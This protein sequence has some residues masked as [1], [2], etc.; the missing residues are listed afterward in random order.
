MLHE[1][2]E[3]ATAKPS[4]VPL[5]V[6][7]ARHAEALRQRKH[8][9][10]P[11]AML[12]QFARA[13]DART[14]VLESLSMRARNGLR[15]VHLGTDRFGNQYWVGGGQWA[16]LMIHSDAPVWTTPGTGASADRY[17]AEAVRKY[18]ADRGTW[19]TVSNPWALRSLVFGYLSSQGTAEA[20]LTWRLRR[21][22]PL[23][24]R[25]MKKLR[26]CDAMLGTAAPTA[27]VSVSVEHVERAGLL[28]GLCPLLAMFPEDGMQ[29]F[30]ER[31]R[32][33][34][35][36][37]AKARA[38]RRRRKKEQRK[39]RRRKDRSNRGRRGGSDDESESDSDEDAAI[40]EISGSAGPLRLLDHQASV[41]LF[42]D[43]GADHILATLAQEQ[44]LRAHRA[45]A[46]ASAAETNYRLVAVRVLL[47]NLVDGLD[48]LV[49]YENSRLVAAQAAARTAARLA[50]KTA[51]LEKV[52]DK[53]ESKS[54]RSKKAAERAAAAYFAAVESSDAAAAASTKAAAA[55]A[56][57]DPIFN[58]QKHVALKRMVLRA[59]TPRALMACL[60]LLEASVG[61]DDLPKWWIKHYR[62][63]TVF[64]GRDATAKMAEDSAASAAAASTPGTDKAVAAAAAARAH[65]QQRHMEPGVDAAAVLLAAPTTALVASRALALRDAL[66][67]RRDERDGV[68]PAHLRGVGSK[69][70][71]T[72]WQD[73]RGLGGLSTK[74]RRP[75][76]DESDGT[77][78]LVKMDRR[79]KA[80][81]PP[82]EVVMLDRAGPAAVRRAGPAV[83]WGFAGAPGETETVARAAGNME[84]LLFAE[85]MEL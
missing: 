18:A 51:A 66:K 17:S 37:D 74:R 30:A 19:Y 58:L 11:T 81:V 13:F 56:A 77:N 26:A 21:V 33:W 40:A 85:E 16:R 79:M 61:D 15:D 70:G 54:G 44:R 50:A 59:Q 14:S 27:P 49:L 28:G 63:Y 76:K 52:K 72:K 6:V 60:L 22:Y 36:A 2:Q 73:E 53:A 25:T 43:S 34:E 64:G 69:K 29:Q 78:W 8:Q 45:A 9:R 12:R 23:L 55:A 38:E 1:Q 24:L 75:R 7:H 67:E 3:K 42:R 82:L 5:A 68:V 35:V 41:D 80:H 46:S 71:R 32:A 20:G 10:F 31:R 84:G 4:A 47:H 83:R 62:P 48:G 39:W 57:F 65:K